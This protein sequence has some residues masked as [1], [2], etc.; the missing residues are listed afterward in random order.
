MSKAPPLTLAQYARAIDRLAHGAGDLEAR[1]AEIGL[2]PELFEHADE[3]WQAELNSEVSEEGQP[4]PLLADF[5]RLLEHH[6][7]G[8][9]PSSMSLETWL[10]IL[11]G[12]SAGEELTSLLGIQ[13]LSVEEFCLG[14]RDLLRLLTKDPKLAKRVSE[15]LS[16]RARTDRS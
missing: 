4:G 8:H 5:L 1:L 6:H 14:Q 11:R 7:D 13:R 9:A 16:G 2:T 15:L 3:Y 12:L 10:A